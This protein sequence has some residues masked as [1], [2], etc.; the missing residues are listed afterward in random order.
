VDFRAA[1][2]QEWDRYD[3]PRFMCMEGVKLR[4][5][6]NTHVTR[7]MHEGLYDIITGPTMRPPL[8]ALCRHLF[9]F[10]TYLSLWNNV[11]HETIQDFIMQPAR[12]D[13]IHQLTAN[14]GLH[15]V[16]LRDLPDNIR[17]FISGGVLGS[18]RVLS[19][20]GAHIEKVFLNA[21]QIPPLFASPPASRA[22]MHIKV[23][24]GV[25]LTTAA[26]WCR[27][28]LHRL[29]AAS[30]K[31]RARRKRLAHPDNVVD[32][33]LLAPTAVQVEK[34]RLFSLFSGGK[35][36]ATASAV[37]SAKS[38]GENGEEE[39]AD[40]ADVNDYPSSDE[41]QVSI[42]S[43][44]KLSA[45][46]KASVKGSGGATAN[47]GGAGGTARRVVDA[48][49]GVLDTRGEVELEVVVRTSYESSALLDQVRNSPTPVT[50]PY[51]L[52]WV[53]AFV[54]IFPHLKCLCVL[55]CAGSKRVCSGGEQQLPIHARVPRLEAPARADPPRRGENVRVRHEDGEQK[56]CFPRRGPWPPW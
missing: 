53:A 16:K 30:Q 46:P 5:L 10:P 36:T 2:K 50:R 24:T 56:L 26:E 3:I 28:R 13:R 41:E 42:E 11:A 43:S 25:A 40:F 47:P 31:Q 7:A 15:I 14:S 19:G 34:K 20:L 6:T 22:G 48:D 9:K 37:T 33:T 4:Y 55:R 29:Q 12:S 38:K 52:W 21:W 49:T 45:K 8:P 44:S 27:P 35:S 18:D 1:L 54:L 39:E 23:Y 51:F 17:L 32:H